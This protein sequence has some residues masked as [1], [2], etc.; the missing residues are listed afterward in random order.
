MA[1]QQFVQLL[2]A[3]KK[4]TD[5][6]RVHWEDLADEDMFRTRQGGGLIRIGQSSLASTTRKGYTLWVIGPAG[7]IVAEIDFFPEDAGYDLIEDLY[8]SARLQAR[9]GQQIVENIIRTLNPA[10]A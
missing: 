6:R 1:T 5:E 9:G 7:E 10:G 3:L 8:H 2:S 4:G